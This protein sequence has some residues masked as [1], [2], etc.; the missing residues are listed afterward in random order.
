MA[1]TNLNYLR[2]ITEGDTASMKELMQMFIDQVPEFTENL[3][4]YLME[5]RYAELGSEAHKA[6]SSVMIMGMEDL[7]HDLKVLQLATIGGT[8]KESYAQHVK[9]FE[10]ECQ[11]AIE[12]LRLALSKME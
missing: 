5:E 8:K 6:K 11:A 7:G 10:N 1:F 12:E 4:K 2:T 3:N 9:R